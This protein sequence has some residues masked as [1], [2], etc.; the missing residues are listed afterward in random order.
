MIGRRGGADR[1][2]WAGVPQT[3]CED[4]RSEVRQD[5]S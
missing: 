2:G 3:G 1:C 4:S 5:E